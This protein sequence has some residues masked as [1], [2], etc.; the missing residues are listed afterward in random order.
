M[1]LQSCRK[2]DQDKPPG[3]AAG[4]PVYRA[5]AGLGKLTAQHG[6]VRHRAEFV[7]ERQIKLDT[8]W[9]QGT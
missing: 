9:G 5:K 2:I 4:L 3:R 7:Q 6:N 8:A 1:L